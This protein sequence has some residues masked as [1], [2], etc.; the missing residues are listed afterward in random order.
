MKHFLAGL[1]LLSTSLST[2]ADWGYSAPN[3]PAQWG[4][5]PGYSLCSTGA[6]QSP[7]AIESGEVA[8]IRNAFPDQSLQLLAPQWMDSQVEIVNNGHTIQ[9]NYS[10]G[11]QIEFDAKDYEL[12]QF[13][14]HSPSEH[15][16]NERQYPLEVH[17][18]HRTA[19][20]DILV[21]GV[22]FQEGQANPQLSK[23]WK[24]APV[25][26]ET[27]VQTAEVLNA[28]DLLPVS[29][30]YFTYTGSLTTPP[31]SEGVRWIVMKEPMEASIDQLQFLQRTLGFT[32]NRPAQPLDGRLISIAVED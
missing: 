15:L 28:L 2:Y 5:L 18:V 9:M 13:H 20:G 7:I 30:E 32:N 11:S 1:V 12:K 19:S 26:P 29:K 21:V 31:C 23:L 10:A 24:N 22:F 14:F 25:I 16:L 4:N 8:G 3:G 27:T 17:F 6:D